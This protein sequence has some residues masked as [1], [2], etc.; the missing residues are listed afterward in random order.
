[1]PH[2]TTLPLIAP[3]LLP[4]HL[5]VIMDGNGRWA[6]LKGLPRTEGHKAG[7][8]SARLVVEECQRLGIG[9]LTLYTFSQE[10]WK[11]PKSEVSFLFD[12]LVDFI[13]RELPV[14][15]KRG[16]RLAVLGH[17]AELPFTTRKVL[18]HAMERTSHGTSMTL[19]LALNYSGRQEIV[20]ACTAYHAAHGNMEGLTPETLANYL[21]TAGQPDPDM[22]LRTSGELRLSNFLPYQSAY[23]ELY[24]TE[25]LWP[26]FTPAHLH[27]ALRAFAHRQRRFGGLAEEKTT[28]P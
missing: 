25:T 9:F 17:F 1:M 3:E 13:T 22:V 4:S 20:D 14:L 21:Y 12:L 8:A 18:Q 27:E 5:A 26:D 10:N 7:V 15:E 11:R 28:T 16:V 19:N 6:T 23:S 24:F 2:T